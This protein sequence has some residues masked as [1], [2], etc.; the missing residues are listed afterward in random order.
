M[1]GEDK[2]GFACHSDGGLHPVPASG[3]ERSGEEYRV[4]SVVTTTTRSHSGGGVH[5]ES[6]V[7]E[8]SRESGRGAGAFVS[9]PSEGGVTRFESWSKGIG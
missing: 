7:R 1:G 3:A 6:C 5:W 9:I 8:G 4:E 2:E